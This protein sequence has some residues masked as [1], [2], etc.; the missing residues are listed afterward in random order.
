M[1]E[2]CPRIRIRAEN[3]RMAIREALSLRFYMRRPHPEVAQMVVAALE[4]YYREVGPTL[5]Q[6]EYENRYWRT[7]DDTG[8]R[9]IREGMLKLPGPEL[10]LADESAEENRYGFSYLGQDAKKQSSWP[11]YVCSMCFWLP[12]EYLEE[13]GPARV[14]QLALE[15]AGTL[16]ICSGNVGLSFREDVVGTRFVTELAFRH[17]GLDRVEIDYDSTRLGTRVHA[18]SWM[19]FL[20]QPALG[21]VGGVDGLRSRLRSP[22]TTVQELGGE[23]A[24]IT[25]GPW[26][27]AGDTQQGLGLPAYRELVRVLEPC[28]YREQRERPY[29]EHFNFAADIRRWERRFLD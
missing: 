23:R 29:A 16:P 9:Y 18:P 25:L 22:G 4:R 19:T 21:E 12:T 8:W 6:Y 17:P 15:L 14:R 2:R 10:E 1:S 27:E 20:G 7:V 3:G 5:A 11:G 28:L 13:H 26:P 24:V